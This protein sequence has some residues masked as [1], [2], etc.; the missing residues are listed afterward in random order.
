MTLPGFGLER[1]YADHLRRWFYRPAP[2]LRE[3]CRSDKPHSRHKVR[4]L[5][6]SKNH[7][8]RG[9]QPRPKS[10]D[11]AAIIKPCEKTLWFIHPHPA[12]SSASDWHW[13]RPSLKTLPSQPRQSWGLIKRQ[14]GD[15]INLLQRGY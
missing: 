1:L 14:T 9:L 15:T 13:S 10:F 5:N 11:A 7:A 8:G 3:Y 6:G 4:Y 12:F 2:K